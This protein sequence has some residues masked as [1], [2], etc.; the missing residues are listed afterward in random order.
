MK[1]ASQMTYHRKILS[2]V[3]KNFILS[4]KITGLK[5]LKTVFYKHRIRVIFKS[6]IKGIC[7]I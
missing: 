4:G 2:H 7:V 1:C 6:T 5:N 3:M